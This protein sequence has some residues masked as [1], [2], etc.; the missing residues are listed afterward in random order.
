MKRGLFNI[1][2]CAFALVG[3][4][5][6]GPTLAH[7]AEAPW[8]QSGEIE[9]QLDNGTLTIRPA[10]G[11]SSG[12][13]HDVP[14][15]NRKNEITAIVVE[16]EVIC[17]FSSWCTGCGNLETA[18]VQGMRSNYRHPNPFDFRDC[19]KLKKIITGEGF[20]GYEPGDPNSMEHSYF[21]D[22]YWKNT[23]NGELYPSNQIPSGMATTWAFYSTEATPNMWVNSG[24]AKWGVFDDCLKIKAQNGYDKG[25]F[26]E[27]WNGNHAAPWNKY[28]SSISSIVVEDS[29]RMTEVDYDWFRDYP[30][31]VSADIRGAIS[32][33]DF[34]SCPKLKTITTGRGF[35]GYNCTSNNMSDSSRF[36]QGFW[37]SNENGEL[38]NYQ[39]IPAGVEA[40]WEYYAEE[41]STE[42]WVH[43]GTAK[44]GCFDGKL[45]V[46]PQDGQEV[47]DFT[48]S[49]YVDPRNVPWE[50]IAERIKTAVVSETVIV[51]SGENL[52]SECT[53]LQ[54]ADL[55]GLDLSNTSTIRD[56]FSGCKSLKSIDL[57][58]LDTSSLTSASYAF[59]NCSCLTS[60]N[61]SSC[62]FSKL[63]ECDRMFSG[64]DA[65][66]DVNLGTI[67]MPK[68]QDCSY[69]FEMCDSLTSVDLSGLYAPNITDMR[70]M[71]ASCDSLQSI[72]LSG[73]TI[74]NV[75]DMGNLFGGCTSLESLD[76]RSFDTRAVVDMEYMF[77]LWG[78]KLKKL[79]VGE[80]FSFKG[81]AS[82]SNQAVLEEGSRWK[83]SA[84][85]KV[86][87]YNSLPSCVAATYTRVDDP[88]NPE[89]PD[90]WFTDVNKNTDHYEHII[91]LADNGVSTGYPD[92]S[93]RPM[94]TVVRQDMAAFLYRLAGSPEYTPTAQDKKRFSDITVNTPHAKEIWWLASE[95]ISSGYND[96]TF[97]PMTPVYRQDMSAFLHRLCNQFGN[98][99]EAPSKVSFPDVNSKTPHAQDIEWLAS[100][101]ISMGYPDG[102]FRPMVPVYRQD[103]AAF[104]HRLYNVGMQVD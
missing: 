25:E 47:G 45:T 2:V 42:I 104:L 101:G 89:R 59:A 96:G 48:L 56:M 93:F 57:S 5:A 100:V 30:N 61:L 70:G 29:T 13:L 7:A 27:F 103:M 38:Y 88:N 41:P 76:L 12:E 73:F 72:N 44:W 52:F 23:R 39:E 15:E 68:L 94:G 22:G 19:P 46:K 97:R 95:S 16:D 64:C 49:R 66:R 81:Y 31:L 35:E 18:D 51:G 32:N 34:S 77:P 98:G 69:M 14:W 74:A 85:G 78:S 10:N 90:I 99:I 83:S 84:D 43:A 86:Y 50:K 17:G 67:E 91:W 80:N 9:W 11:A 58:A 71:F 1:V 87:D 4:L 92:G 75:V 6:A 55:T 53:R 60:I 102:T 62:D 3:L 36:P 40:T 20:I 82:P 8:E 21:P 37:K 54:S 28:K 33:P 63:E 26:D 24:T 65:L 79:T